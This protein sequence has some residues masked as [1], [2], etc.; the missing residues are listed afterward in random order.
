MHALRLGYKPEFV[1]SHHPFVRPHDHKRQAM[2]RS[3]AFA[4]SFYDR[5]P[6]DGLRT[7]AHVA[8]EMGHRVVD[9][10]R[11]LWDNETERHVGHAALAP[12]VE[13]PETQV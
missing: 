9:A 11:A 12:A 5:A 10:A 1:E 13:P 3:D 6:G 2:R 8:R 4:A 7:L